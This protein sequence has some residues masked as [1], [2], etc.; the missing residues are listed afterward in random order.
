LLAG[1]KNELGPDFKYAV[2]IWLGMLQIESLRVRYSKDDEDV[3]K[4]INFNLNKEKVSI[5]GPNGSGKSTIFRAI[6]GL[7]PISEGKVLVFGQDV[8]WVR[9]MRGVTTNIPEVYRV[10]NLNVGD[11]T[12]VYAD[13]MGFSS[14]EILKLV[15]DFELQGTLRKKLFQLS[16]GQQKMICNILAVGFN[17]KL[18][19]LDEPFDNVD[20]NRRKRFA[21]LLRNLECEIIMV[22]HEFD[23]LGQFTGWGLYFI[24]EGRLWGRF[25]IT[26]L[27][28]LYIS[29]GEVDGAIAVIKTASGV[30]SVTFDTGKIRLSSATNFSSILEAV[31]E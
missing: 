2:L 19:L 15:K 9:G 28:R 24:I 21:E 11:L 13:M 5:V 18:V 27:Q 14:G 26:D 23:L 31:T 3:L 29:P 12:E 17:P 7:A 8:K 6:L 22:T 1:S 20:Q 30:F 25:N 16:T 4:G 10:A